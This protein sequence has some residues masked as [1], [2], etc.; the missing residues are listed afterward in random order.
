[1]NWSEALRKRWIMGSSRGFLE[2]KTSWRYFMISHVDWLLDFF[3]VSVC[4]SDILLCHQISAPA[5]MKERGCTM[6]KE[7]ANYAICISLIF[8][9]AWTPKGEAVVLWQPLC[10]AEYLGPHPAVSGSKKFLN[11]RK[12]TKIRLLSIICSKEKMERSLC[13]WQVKGLV[14]QWKEGFWNSDGHL[15]KS[16]IDRYQSAHD[17]PKFSPTSKHSDSQPT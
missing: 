14:A 7:K 12:W 4:L 16:T 6:R 8:V 17:R 15:P 3:H 2:N 10:E 1:M 13:S 9:C 5:K 11:A